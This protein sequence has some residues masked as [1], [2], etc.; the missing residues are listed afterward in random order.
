MSGAVVAGCLLA[1]GVGVTVWARG[2]GA[3]DHPADKIEVNTVAVTRTDLSTSHS[4]RGSLGY[5]IPRAIKG[6]RDG[7]VTW[8]PEAGKMIGRGEVLYRVNDDPVPLFTGSPPL[9]R[10]LS[11]RNTVGR[12]VAMVAENLKALGYPIGDQPQAGE[13]VEQSGAPSTDRQPSSGAGTTAPGSVAGKAPDAAG[14]SAQA[15][16]TRVT[17]RAGDGVLTNSLINAIKKW[18]R[19]RG[20]PGD[21]R[22]DVGDIAVLP[23]P[24]RVN[25]VTG[26][27]G[28]SATGNLM[29]VT[30]TTKLVTVQAQV[31]E[32]DSVK[33]GDAATVRLP[34]GTEAPGK[35]GAIATV[36][37][38]P[39]QQGPGD[40]GPQTIAVTVTLDNPDAAGRLDGGNVDVT[41]A[42]E[43]RSGVLTVPV[44]ALLALR[45]GGYALQL[46][47]GRLLPVKTGLFA[48]GMVEI[49]GNGLREGL[50]VVT[51]S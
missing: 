6:G 1:V 42:G 43:T 20:L 28:D 32:T 18:Q 39:D 26:V 38:S 27:I 30:Q 15:T 40:G 33:E 46:E 2:V 19:D 51:T 5:G 34:N 31:A 45:E 22:L 24:V 8:L 12:D 48:R 49:T 3:A 21:G 17:V 7:V 50:T 13:V 44:N 37:Q 36:A 9:Y 29:S 4:L 10:T 47:D 16:S 14:S 25:A 41:V 11:E 35:V 23:G